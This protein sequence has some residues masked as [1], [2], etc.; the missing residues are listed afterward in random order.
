MP[1]KEGG[2]FIFLKKSR[3]QQVTVCLGHTHTHTHTHTRSYYTHAHRANCSDHRTQQFGNSLP[4]HGQRTGLPH[5]KNS[6]TA[7]THTHKFCLWPLTFLSSLLLLPAPR[8]SPSPL[9]SSPPLHP[10][11]PPSSPPPLLLRSSQSQLTAS[12]SLDVIACPPSYKSSR[13]C[14]HP[15]LATAESSD[16]VQ[17][18][19]R[20]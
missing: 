2:Q 7:H 19:E 14:L 10:R 9:C 5:K 17:A 11:R 4:A 12:F 8:P 1:K 13:R 18:Q 16:A 6:H 3:S 15:T 20:K